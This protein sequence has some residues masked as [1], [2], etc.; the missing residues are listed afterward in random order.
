VE[1]DRTGNSGTRSSTAPDERHCDPGDAAALAFK[2]AGRNP[3]AGL[4]GAFACVCAGYS[5]GFTIDALYPG[6]TEEAVKVLPNGAEAVTHIL[7]N[8]FFTATASIVLGLLGGFLIARVLE[9]RLPWPADTDQTA[10]VADAE[11]AK[12][13]SAQRRG[14]LFSGLAVAAYF[15]V[16]LTVWLLP[17]SPL[18]GEDGTL[19]PSPA[20]SGVVPLLF[21]AF[22]MAGIAYGFTARTLTKASDLPQLMADSVTSMSS[23][24]VL[25][26]AIGQLI[27]VFNW[28]GVAFD[29]T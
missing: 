21:V 3:I 19:V 6:I 5:A 17:D 1:G 16:V 13:T 12:F 4:I 14:L 26:F 2:S 10:Q 29:I 23:H 8:Y 27:A 9:P 11:T 24:I 28:S 22:V 7:I 25:I 18:R 15:A 20:L